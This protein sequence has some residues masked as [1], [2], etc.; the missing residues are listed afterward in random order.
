[1]AS[2]NKVILL[3]NLTRDPELRVTPGG[4]AICKIG[5]AVNRRYK[6]AT[7]ED[8]EEVTF[9]DLDAFGKQAEIL[10]KYVSKGSMLFVEGR[11]RLDQWDGNQG[12]KRSK[13]SVVVENFQLMPKGGE[14]ASGGN[15]TNYDDVSPPTR[16]TRSSTT[17]QPIEDIEDDVPF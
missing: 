3:G 11:L 6:S 13:I 12:E 17:S 8:K 15:S 1:M 5:L 14:R 16:S 10:G 4:L 9:L 2:F 7:G